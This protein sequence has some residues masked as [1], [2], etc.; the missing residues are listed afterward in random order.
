VHSIN[1]II[2]DTQHSTKRIPLNLRNV[3]QLK[4][5]LPAA[6]NGKTDNTYG[7]IGPLSATAGR[8]QRS[9]GRTYWVVDTTALP[10]KR[11]DRENRKERGLLDYEKC[12]E[13]ELKAFIQSRGLKLPTA[14]P[15]LSTADNHRY[16]IP[17]DLNRFGLTKSNYIA[18][19]KQADDT[20]VFHKFSDLAPELRTNVYRKYCQGLPELPVLPHQPP[21]TLAS[22]LLCEEALPIFYE[23]C[24]FVLRFH[25]NTEDI[26][27]NLA[28]VVRSYHAAKDPDHLTS[29][30]LSSSNFS[31]IS[32]L[33]LRICYPHWGT[34]DS[35]SWFI[36]LN[37]EKGPTLLRRDLAFFDRYYRHHGLYWPA[38]CERLETKIM[39]VLQGIWERPGTCKFLYSD[40]EALRL[41]I[42]EASGPVE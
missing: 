15:G 20:A 24:T 4:C 12:T 16:H 30:N 38:R 10:T 17:Y 41:A 37:G 3:V 1:A 33:H 11:R 25:E 13:T 22:K 29:A 40:M 2:S 27:D 9:R 32:R 34:E 39:A 31:R 5:N 21:L 42:L 35:G 18:T 8:K 28:P 26:H 36:D 19:L 14:T 6:L 23:Q 7:A